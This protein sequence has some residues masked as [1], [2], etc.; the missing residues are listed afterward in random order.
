MLTLAALLLS[1]A[2]AGAFGVARLRAARQDSLVDQVR[3]LRDG[4][5]V[6]LD[7]LLPERGAHL[8]D[9]VH[10]LLPQTQC[11][12]CGQPG[13][14]PYAVAVVGG[15][16]ANRCLPGG[17]PVARAIAELLARPV[18]LPAVPAPPP[19]VVRIR[20]DTCIGCTRCIPVCPVDAIVGA[21]QHMHTVL[22]ANCT[23]CGLCIPPCPVD[24]IEVVPLVVALEVRHDPDDGRAAPCINCGA[25][26]DVCPERLQPHALLRLLDAA[27]LDAA[28]RLG[29]D[30]CTAC[31]LCDPVCPSRIP[32][33]A[34][35]VVARGA[36]ARRVAARYAA[37][38]AGARYV[39]HLQR[40]AALDEQRARQRALR[41]SQR[42]PA[43]TGQDDV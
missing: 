34:A 1:A 28:A 3:Q 32:L 2:L 4:V 36:L 39:T 41:L 20:E 25:C 11:E 12:Q 16:A 6:R 8:V 42:H 26:A 31:G 10:K 38:D 43:G 14:R 33:R 19:S 24:C 29:L 23:G 27:Q 15:E 5:R 9:G 35:F 17:E 13:C 22:E 18:L 37:Q 40:R 30:A 21:P 7:R